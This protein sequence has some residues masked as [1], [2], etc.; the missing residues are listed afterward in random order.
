M[1]IKDNEEKITISSI[2][3]ECE[4]KWTMEIPVSC[5]MNT[6]FICECGGHFKELEVI[7]VQVK[8]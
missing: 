8:V 5:L 1:I 7:N 2:C 6:V 4:Q 3:P